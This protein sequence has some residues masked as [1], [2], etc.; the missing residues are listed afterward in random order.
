MIL[1]NELRTNRTTCRA[2]AE[3]KIHT[4]PRGVMQFEKQQHIY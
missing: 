4:H 2:I 1:R 3:S